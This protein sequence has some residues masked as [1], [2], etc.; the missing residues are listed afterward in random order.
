MSLGGV[1]LPKRERTLFRFKDLKSGKEFEE[2]A[3]VWYEAKQN[4]EFKNKGLNLSLIG[5]KR[6]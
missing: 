1:I 4:L 6:L 2:I 3:N 5:K